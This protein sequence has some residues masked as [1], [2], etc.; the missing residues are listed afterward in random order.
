MLTSAQFERLPQLLQV[1]VN[2]DRKLVAARP[3]QVV[4]LADARF[5]RSLLRERRD[6]TRAAG[7]AWG[8]ARENDGTVRT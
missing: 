5:Y 7:K 4:S 8:G 3:G 6:L 1:I 2:M